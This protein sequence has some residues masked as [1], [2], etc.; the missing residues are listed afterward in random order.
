[1]RLYNFYKHENST[2][3]VI[4]PIK[5]YYVH[6][7]KTLIIKARMYTIGYPGKVIYMDYDKW[8]VPAIELNKWK[9]FSIDNLTVL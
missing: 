4:E 2:D 1:M 6:E 7:K 9:E 8:E 5:L 3:L